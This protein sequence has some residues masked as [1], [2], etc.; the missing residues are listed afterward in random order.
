[1]II[2]HYAY[3]IIHYH[4]YTSQI[5]LSVNIILV[6]LVISINFH[7]LD[8]CY[9]NF[10]MTTKFVILALDTLRVYPTTG[11]IIL[12]FSLFSSFAHHI[13]IYIHWFGA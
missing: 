8:F 7:N 5:F 12:F 9:L 10:A 4:I 1:M 13:Y 2:V 3:H 6:I 11:G